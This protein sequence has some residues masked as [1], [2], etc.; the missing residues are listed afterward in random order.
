MT[1]KREI[2]VLLFCVGSVCKVNYLTQRGKRIQLA[3]ILCFIFIPLIGVWGFT[4]FS[5][6][7]NVQSKSDTEGVGGFYLRVFNIY[8][9]T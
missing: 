1:F 7:D 5:L 9:Y 8:G 6:F 3:R 2:N 4:I